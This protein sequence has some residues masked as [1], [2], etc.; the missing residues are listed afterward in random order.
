MQAGKSRRRR[1]LRAL[2]P[3]VIRI[4]SE[5]HGEFLRFLR[6]KL[7]SR[8]D[9]DD[10]MQEFHLRIIRY[11]S[12]LRRE[13]S[14]RIWLRRVLRSVL[15]THL[16]RLRARDRAEAD[17]ARKDIAMPP[18]DE[19]L[20]RLVCRC[21]EKLLPTLKPEYADVLRRIDLLERPRDAV[22]EALGMTVNNL[23]VRLHRARQALRRAL[24]L[25]CETCPIHGYLDCGCPYTRRLKSQSETA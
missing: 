11:A 9:A 3:A 23:T 24:E 10:V 22:A 5:V 19:D 21:L 4:L 8:A 18:P 12:S 15:V 14:I 13:E 20:D 6:R 1:A 7:R 25:T 16:R 17:F 2:D